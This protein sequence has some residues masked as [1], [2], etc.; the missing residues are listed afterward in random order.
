MTKN[1]MV[2]LNSFTFSLVFV[3]ITFI[4]NASQ[5]SRTISSQLF[6]ERNPK[7]CTTLRNIFQFNFVW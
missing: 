6:D 2:L 5:A 7:S 1:I 4:S 3:M